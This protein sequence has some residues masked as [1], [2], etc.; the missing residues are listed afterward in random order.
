MFLLLFSSCYHSSLD[1][2]ALCLLLILF[3]FLIGKRVLTIGF[4]D[5]AKCDD[6]LVVVVVFGVLSSGV[7]IESWF[8]GALRNNDDDDERRR[9]RRN[10]PN[11]YYV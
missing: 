2:V 6:V 7:E 3:V 8:A 9:K 1:V 10:A 5:A 4:S 11:Y